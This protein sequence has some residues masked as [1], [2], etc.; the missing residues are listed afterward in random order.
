MKKTG[1]VLAAAGFSGGIGFFFV[2]GGGKP[3]GRGGR[4]PGAGGISPGGESHRGEN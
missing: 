1:A 3:C 2:G 4:R